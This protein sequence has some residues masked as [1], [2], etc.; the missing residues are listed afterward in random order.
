MTDFFNNEDETLSIPY[1]SAFM[2]TLLQNIYSEI[3]ENRTPIK[4]ISAKAKKELKA[5][6]K[7]IL[8]S[9]QNVSNALLL[10]ASVATGE[11]IDKNI[12]TTKTIINALSLQDTLRYAK[13]ISKK[14]E[15]VD[16]AALFQA[17]RDDLST[18]NT[19]KAAKPVVTCISKWQKWIHCFNGS[20]TA[21]TEEA[22][23]DLVNQVVSIIPSPKYL[24][25]KSLSKYRNLINPL[26][27]ILFDLTVHSN[28]YS[29]FILFIKSVNNIA[30]KYPSILINELLSNNRF[31]KD[32]EKITEIL[33]T[34]L[35][36]LI[37]QGSKERINELQ[38]NIRK[39][40]F[41]DL[42]TPFKQ[43][44]RIIWDTKG[45]TFDEDIQLV[46]KHVLFDEPIVQ[47][48]FESISQEGKSSIRHLATTLINAWEACNDSPRA[49]DSYNLLSSVL[50]KYFN[51]MLS[52]NVGETAY[53]NRIAHE[54]LNEKSIADNTGIIIVRPWVE[55][56]TQEKKIILIK[57]LVKEKE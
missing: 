26:F 20:L 44:L 19:I 57:A 21:K 32:T 51:L 30:S 25:D 33:L 9:D 37:L 3:G 24:T 16:A 46:I 8:E 34:H 12:I 13:K 45:A 5:V 23:L 2:E 53:Y 6:L 15:I 1:N 22:L 17:I 42:D 50:K 36:Q 35:E 39:I 27:E 56:Q 49:M 4:K 11:A 7:K 43:R 38:Q 47:Q 10:R 14:E 18:A 55:E 52:K 40:S 41:C 28:F 29:T 48:R 31:I 54:P